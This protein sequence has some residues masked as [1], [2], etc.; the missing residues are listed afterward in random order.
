MTLSLDIFLKNEHN[1]RITDAFEKTDKLSVILNCTSMIQAYQKG[2][3]LQNLA[4]L[5]FGQT[6]KQSSKPNSA[7]SKLRIKIL[8]K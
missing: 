8:I 6:N 4:T 3:L 2:V 1:C 7:T 5:F